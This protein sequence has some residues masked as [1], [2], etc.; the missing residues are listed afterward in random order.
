MAEGLVIKM[1]ETKLASTIVLSTNMK[2]TPGSP[3]NQEAAE[4]ALHFH[5]SL[6][7]YERTRLVS[8]RTVADELGVKAVYLKDESTRF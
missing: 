6:P 8:L 5:R 3:F 7:I 2:G 1:K 4:N